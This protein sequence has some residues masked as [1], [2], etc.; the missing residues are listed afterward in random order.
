MITKIDIDQLW[1]I[2]QLIE[3]NNHDPLSLTTALQGDI[4]KQVINK[5]DYSIIIR[6]ISESL[7][8]V[9]IGCNDDKISVVTFY[10]TIYITPEQV[11]NIYKTYKETYSYRDDLHFYFFN[12]NKGI[13]N[14]KLSFFDPT[15]KK[16][17]VEDNRDNL[18]NLTISWL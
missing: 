15:H 14:H 6:N 17:I 13:E 8:A 3:K 10:G 4:L 7:S 12:D 11:F 5:N 18:S 2:V 16:L 9:V 1:E